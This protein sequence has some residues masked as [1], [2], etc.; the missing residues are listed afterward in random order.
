MASYELTA[1]ANYHCRIGENPLWDDR[2]RRLLW[3]DIPAGRLYRYDPVNG[4]HEPFHQGEVVGGFTLQQ[5]GSLLLFGADRIVLLSESGSCRT[6]A[7]DIDEDM[8]RFN[9]VI[10]APGGQV[11]AGTIGK[12]N[13]SGG[14]YRVGLDGA[15]TCLFKGTGC[16]NGMGFSPDRRRFYWT[17]TTSRTIFE[18]DFDEAACE[19]SG[20]RAFV[21]LDPSEKFPDGMTVD[22][23]GF[24]WSARW[25]GYSI[26]RYTPDGKLVE[27]IE[28]PVAKVSSLTFG[29]LGLDDIYVTT[30]GGS[31][32]A[33]TPDG[34]LY[35]FRTG[36]AGL[37]EFRSSVAIH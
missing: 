26:G 5:D 20:R 36:A 12:T 30:A 19:L 8:Q 3:T 4:F 11:L 22:R 6:V 16:S 9:D 10:A 25:D 29:G 35:R 31:Q 7:S 2:R 14:L 17:D 28:L 21:T 27:T 1:L 24:V 34:T 32:G 18:F 23:D 37:P 15:A 13:Q 33:D